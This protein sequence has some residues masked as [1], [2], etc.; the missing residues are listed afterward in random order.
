MRDLFDEIQ[1]D[2]ANSFRNFSESLPTMK[3]PSFEL[4]DEGNVFMVIVAV[5]GMSKD[6]IT[7]KVDETIDGALLTISGE[8]KEEEIEA[9]DA[10]TYRHGRVYQSSFS[11]TLRLPS[12]VL[13]EGIK[14]DLKDGILRIVLP[15]AEIT[16]KQ[17]HTIAISVQ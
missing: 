8:T 9:D 3:S 10:K 12:M 2:V 16:K 7:I 11:Q 1:R 17:S 14:A 4:T 5:P 13:V 6:S 15:K